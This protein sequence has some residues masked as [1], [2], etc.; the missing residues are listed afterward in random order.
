MG[1]PIFIMTLNETNDLPLPNLRA[2]IDQHG[3]LAVGFAYLR[4]ALMRNP[5]PPDNLANR[6]SDHLLRDIGLVTRTPSSKA[7]RQGWNF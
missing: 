4:A 7:D 6:L 3:S 1:G 2:L 5:R